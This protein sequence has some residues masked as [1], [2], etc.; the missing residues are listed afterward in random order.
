MGTTRKS[1]LETNFRGVVCGGHWPWRSSSSYSRLGR[2]PPGSSFFSR[3]DSG[4]ST[5]APG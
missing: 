1:I 3:V 5:K 4:K 2:A